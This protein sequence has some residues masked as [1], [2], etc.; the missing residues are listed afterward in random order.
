M[1]QA[2]T[3]RPDPPAH[4]PQPDPPPPPDVQF[5]IGA[6]DRVSFAAMPAYRRA[7]IQLIAA[8]SPRRFIEVGCHLCD[9]SLAVLAAFPNIE[10]LAVDWY[11]AAKRGSEYH[12]SGDAFANPE[13]D[14]QD[15]QDTTKQFARITM[16]RHEIRAA[17]L[18]ADSQT[19]AKYQRDGTADAVFLDCG[20]DFLSVARGLEE[21]WPKIRRG[22][23]LIGREW[24]GSQPRRQSAPTWDQSEAKAAVDEFCRPTRT[25]AT[26]RSELRVPRWFRADDRNCFWTIA[27]GGK[28]REARGW[29]LSWSDRKKVAAERESRENRHPGERA[30]HR[31]K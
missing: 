20:Y 28:P 5:P 2:E 16:K 10:V 18:T 1:R 9:T 30:D 7:V 17:L 15:Q 12:R 21:W 25:T 19:A 23:V 26:P 31:E 22:G 4:K 14:F 13:L 11:R 27:K 24:D 29:E 8:C 3:I 6:I